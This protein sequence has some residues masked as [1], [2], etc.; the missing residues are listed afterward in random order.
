MSASQAAKRRRISAVTRERLSPAGAAVS[1]ALH[2]ALVAAFLFTWQHKLDITDESPPVVPVDLITVGDKTNVEAIEKPTPPPKQETP[3]PPTEIPKPAPE[4]AEAAPDIA[5]TKT[6]LP[7]EA[8]TPPTI[9]PRVRPQPPPDKSFDNLLNQLTAPDK[10]STKAKLGDRTVKGVGMQTGMTMDLVD[11]IRNQMS[12]CWTPPSGAPNP[13]D[14]VVDFD[15]VLNQDGS[16]AQPPQLS[17]QSAMA[18]ARNPYTRAAAE[19]ARRAI[20]TCAPYKLPSDRY[21]QWREIDPF[22]FDPRQMMG[23]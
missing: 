4:Q 11:A 19:A 16:I 17:A 10:P 12:N 7:K 14:L 21:S 15:L 2:G 23:Q 6:V 8:P 22:H 13:Q 20:Y 3:P 18:A 9:A 5:P 1:L